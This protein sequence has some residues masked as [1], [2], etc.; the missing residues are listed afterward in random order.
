MPVGTGTE[1]LVIPESHTDTSEITTSVAEETTLPPVTSEVTGEETTLQ[2]PDE[3]TTMSPEVTDEETTAPPVIITYEFDVIEESVDIGTIGTKTCK[4]VLRFPK[5]K[6]LENTSLQNSVNELLGQIAQVEFENRLPNANELVKS[7][8]AVDYEIKETSITFMGNNLISVRSE[9]IIDYNDESKDEK[10]VYCNLI[11]LSTGRDITLKKTYSDFGSVMSLFTS[12][13]F[14]QI[15]GSASLLSSTTLES[16]MEQYKYFSQYGTFPETYFT[17][18]SLV[19]IVETNREN[20]HFAE[21]SISL[22]SV[23][24]YL[25]QSPTK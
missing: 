24:G 15:S 2:A 21:F 14:K 8:T 20:G 1:A 6:G 9:G 16:L 18:D 23:N 3:T 22:D 11:N 10:F 19:I 17:A 25:Y 4:K 5:L 13:K 12:G 7:G